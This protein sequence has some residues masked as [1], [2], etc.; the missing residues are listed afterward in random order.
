[1]PSDAEVKDAPPP[2]DEP[3]P[4][5]AFLPDMEAEADDT[6]DNDEMHEDPHDDLPKGA[7]AE[8]YDDDPDPSDDADAEEDE[9]RERQLPG[10]VL[11]EH[12]D[13]EEETP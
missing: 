7:R 13:S 10:D 3:V 5:A 8:D 6:V 9:E 11:K 4:R 2:Q 12:D 1:M